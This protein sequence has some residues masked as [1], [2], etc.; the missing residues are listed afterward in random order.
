MS[1]P[2]YRGRQFRCRTDPVQLDHEDGA[3]SSRK[4][5]GTGYSLSLTFWCHRAIRTGV[6]AGSSAVASG[7]E[8]EALE[9]VR[10]GAVNIG[11]KG[12]GKRLRG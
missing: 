11:T 5:H 9:S 3:L 6:S 2:W 8:M 1:E 4:S 10:V 12:D 7:V